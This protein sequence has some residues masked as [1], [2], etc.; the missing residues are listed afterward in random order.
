MIEWMST[1]SSLSIASSRT[2]TSA[3]AEQLGLG[4]V[5]H[6]PGAL[7]TGGDEPGEA[8]EGARDDPGRREADEVGHKR[9]GQESRAVGVAHRPLLGDG[10][11]ED[12]DHDDLEDRRHRDPERAEDLCRDDADQGGGHELAEQHEQQDRGEEGLGFLDEAAQ[13]ACTPVPGVL[14]RLG[15]DP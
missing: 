8:D 1:R 7:R 4:H 11:G 9:R 10:L 12:E 15:P 5:R 13:R 3:K 2:A 14:E 6:G